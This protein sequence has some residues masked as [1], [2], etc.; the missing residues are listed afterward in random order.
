MDTT[1]Q[2]KINLTDVLPENIEELI[3]ACDIDI[4]TGCVKPVDVW[5]EYLATL[6]LSTSREA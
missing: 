3:E 5:M 4:D 1:P 6:P 2:M